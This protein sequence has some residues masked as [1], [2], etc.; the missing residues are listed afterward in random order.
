M[1]LTDK[2]HEESRATSSGNMEINSPRELKQL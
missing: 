1:S 2:F